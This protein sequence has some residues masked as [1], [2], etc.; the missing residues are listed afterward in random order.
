MACPFVVSLS[1]HNGQA[2]PLLAGTVACNRPLKYVMRRVPAP[3]RAQEAQAVRI[4]RITVYQADL[5]VRHGGFRQSSGRIWRVLDTSVVRMETDE[6]VTGWGETCP[7]RRE[8][9]PRLRR[10]RARRHGVPRAAAHRQEPMRRRRDQPADGHG[11]VRHSVRQGRA[12]QRVLGH[13]RPVCRAARVH[14]ARGQADRPVPV[15]RRLRDRSRA[16]PR[17]RP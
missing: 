9:R 12:G 8:L 2:P 7:V 11:D 15:R 10:G 6:G 3:S 17:T 16:P 5:P 13:P 1:N 4:T 14:A